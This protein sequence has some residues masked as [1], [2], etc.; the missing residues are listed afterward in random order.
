MFLV[1]GR[2]N[3][4]SA[5]DLDS[6]WA[7]WAVRNLERKLVA[8]AEFVKHN[9]YELV[10]VEEEILLHTFDLDETESLVRKTSNS[11]CLH[12]VVC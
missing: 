2:L 12:G 6:V 5:A 3:E 1:R 9:A 4:L 7:L 8:L 10:G 11:S